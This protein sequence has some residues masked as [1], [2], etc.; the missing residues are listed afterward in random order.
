MLCDFPQDVFL[1]SR[2]TFARLALSSAATLQ[3]AYVRRCPQQQG[4][5]ERLSGVFSTE[6]EGITEYDVMSDFPI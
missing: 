1:R 5:Q 2:V 3:A 4:Q 6:Y